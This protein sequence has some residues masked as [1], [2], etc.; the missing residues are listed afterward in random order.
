[1]NLFKGLTPKIYVI[2][3]EVM[4]K[5]PLQVHYSLI[6]EQSLVQFSVQVKK[7]LSSSPEFSKA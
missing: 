3:Y 6:L 1:M 7:L 4:R 5:A 2:F